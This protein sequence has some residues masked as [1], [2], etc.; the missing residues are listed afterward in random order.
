MIA[1]FRFIVIDIS[2]LILLLATDDREPAE[3]RDAFP[4][5][6]WLAKVCSA[7]SK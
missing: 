3:E 1:Q 7:I 6:W 5:D 4:I 2:R